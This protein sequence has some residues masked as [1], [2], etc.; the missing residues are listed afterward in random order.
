MHGEQ[1]GKGQQDRD[2]RASADADQGAVHC[3]VL[4]DQRVGLVE[5]CGGEKPGI[6]GD[7]GGGG[8]LEPW[9]PVRGGEGVRFT[10]FRD[11]LR[12]LLRADPFTPFEIELRDGKV[13]VNTPNRL[14]MSG[15]FAVLIDV[16]K[17]FVV[18]SDADVVRITPEVAD[19]EGKIRETTVWTA[20][21]STSL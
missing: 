18:F 15:R 21:I 9:L 7:G 3:H 14:A 17:P 16:P 8:A 11:T 10:R 4:S 20:C 5:R 2:D 6:P 19:P 13:R 1:G 12:T